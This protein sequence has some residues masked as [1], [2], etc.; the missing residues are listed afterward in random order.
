MQSPNFVT[1]YNVVF[2]GRNIYLHITDLLKE[3]FLAIQG[4]L[5]FKE[6]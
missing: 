6:T 2:I 1:P 4:N 5:I 3:L